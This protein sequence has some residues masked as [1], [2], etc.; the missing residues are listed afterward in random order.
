MT[1]DLLVFFWFFCVAR[2]KISTIYPAQETMLVVKNNSTIPT[3]LNHRN[4]SISNATLICVAFG[5]PSPKLRWQATS[6]AKL[7]ASFTTHSDG[8][9]SAVLTMNKL[10]P[11]TAVQCVAFN[12]TIMDKQIVLIEEVNDSVV[13]ETS[14][15]SLT[16]KPL[17]INFVARLLLTDYCDSRSVSDVYTVPL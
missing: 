11:V 12:E 14:E 15:S 8:V 1:F 7:N 6:G 13:Q 5:L 16:T 4:T 9:V 10:L 17:T 3:F 2:A